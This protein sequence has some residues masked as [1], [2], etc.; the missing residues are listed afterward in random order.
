MVRLGTST[1]LE[2][3]LRTSQKALRLSDSWTRRMQRMRWQR[4]TVRCMMGVRC[5]CSWPNTVAQTSHHPEMTA[6]VVTEGMIAIGEIMVGGTTIVG[7][8]T[9]ETMIAEIMT[10]VTVDPADLKTKAAVTDMIEGITI[11]GTIR[12]D[13]MTAVV[14]A[15]TTSGVS[16]RRPGARRETTDTETNVHST[17]EEIDPHLVTI[18]AETE[19]ESH[20]RSRLRPVRI[21]RVPKRQMLCR[22]QLLPTFNGH[23]SPHPRSSR[24]TFYT[25]NRHVP[26]TGHYDRKCSASRL[27]CGLFFNDGSSTTI[28]WFECRRCRSWLWSQERNTRRRNCT[29]RWRAGRGSG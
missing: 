27:A 15:K 26:Y 7:I 25:V 21:A 17:T 3:A 28:E 22:R 1:Y 16:A 13:E 18:A 6:M 29:C 2:I 5:E 8:M 11:A 10:A 12:R 24:P 19:Y 20:C 9:A 23:S 4:S 14:V